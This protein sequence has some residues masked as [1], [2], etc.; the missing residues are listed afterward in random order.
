M[1]AFSIT[2]GKPIQV[3]FCDFNNK[4]KDQSARVQQSFTRTELE[5]FVLFFRVGKLSYFL[6]TLFV[7]LRS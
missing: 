3:G 2:L 1:Q 7:L 4:K 5:T 6:H